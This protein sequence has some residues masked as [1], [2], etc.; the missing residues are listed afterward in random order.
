M[1]EY[2]VRYCVEKNGSLSEEYEVIPVEA[3]S[4]EESLSIVKDYLVEQVIQNSDFTAEIIK[5]SVVVYDGEEIIETYCGFSVESEIKKAREEAGI[6][7]RAEMSRL[8]E[9]PVRT[10]EDWEYG[11]R[12]PIHWAENLI[13]EKLEDIKNKKAA[14]H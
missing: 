3:S 13:I 9:I 10:L 5:D 8:F 6:K 14:D 4:T 7:S 11:K 1:R 12:I 2:K